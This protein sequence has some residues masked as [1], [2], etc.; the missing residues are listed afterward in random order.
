MD[1]IFLPFKM[2]QGARPSVASTFESCA[3]KLTGYD[4]IHVL[5]SLT[6]LPREIRDR[7]YG[8]LVVSL[9]PVIV[10]CGPLDSTVHLQLTDKSCAINFLHG[11]IPQSDLATEVC[12]VFF[13]LNTFECRDLESLGR[14]LVSQPDLGYGSQVAQSKLDRESRETE[15]CGLSKEVLIGVFKKEWVRNLQ[16]SIYC[17]KPNI[18]APEVRPHFLHKC[19]MLNQY[20]NFCVLT[21]FANN[22]DFDFQQ[23]LLAL[24]CRHLQRLNIKLLG[25]IRTVHQ[26]RQALRPVLPPAGPITPSYHLRLTQSPKSPCLQQIQLQAGLYLIDKTIEQLANLIS[27]ARRKFGN[28][29]TVQVRKNWNNRSLYEWSDPNIGSMEDATWMWDH[30]SKEVQ[31]QVRNGFGSV[32]DL[33]NV[34]MLYGW[35]GWD[36]SIGPWAELWQEDHDRRVA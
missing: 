19:P 27:V 28:G 3:S 24:K 25:N 21:C 22:A 29:L 20:S 26:P 4:S 11:L 36:G 17:A 14:F 5:T 31:D 23:L 15:T 6:G 18:K 1:E 32:R 13:K 2:D 7:I 35:E 10:Q 34:F 16:L 30:P 33:I 9:K 12:E 8:E